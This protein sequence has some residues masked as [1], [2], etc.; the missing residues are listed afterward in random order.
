MKKFQLLLTILFLSNSF[1]VQSQ[2]YFEGIL[3]FKMKFQDKT[4]KLTDK[5][6]EQYMGNQQTYYLKGKNYKSELNGLLEMTTYYQ[7]RDTLFTKMKGINSLMYSLTNVRE[8]K[9]ISFKIKKTKKSILGYK[10]KLLEIKTN[11]GFHQYFY[12]NDLTCDSKTFENH[13]MG[14]WDFFTEKTNGALPII[15]ISDVEDYKSYTELISVVQKKLDINIF[16]KPDFP[17][18]KM[19]KN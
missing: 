16:K 10:C 1:L 5:Q 13:K 6:S 7:G 11:K 4:G 15:S 14:L 2:E 18:I 17:I 8:E 9:I 12:S 3:T 19:P